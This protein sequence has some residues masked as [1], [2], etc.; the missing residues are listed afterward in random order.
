MQCHAN[1]AQSAALLETWLDR[2]QGED[3]RERMGMGAH[4]A[5]GDGQSAA[6]PGAAMNLAEAREILGVTESASHEEIIAAHRKLMQKLHPDRGGSTW[7][8]TKV[9]QAKDML[10]KAG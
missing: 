1:D 5:P 7:L 3:W 10:L 4:D 9:N 8:A 6:Q 2:T